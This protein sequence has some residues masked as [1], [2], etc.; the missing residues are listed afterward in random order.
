MAKTRTQ[1]Q[2]EVASYVEKIQ[3]S[4]AMYFVKPKG[5]PAPM[6]SDLKMKLVEDEA[7]LN[8][9]K[10][11]LF[12]KAI[13]SANLNIKDFTDSFSDGERA[14]LFA[15]GDVVKPMKTLKEFIAAN[16]DKVEIIAGYYSGKFISKSS[17]L[18][19]AD[20]PDYSSMMAKTLA[21]LNGV[22]TNFVRVS[23]NNIERLINVLNAVA[24]KK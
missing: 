19:I 21:T 11:T 20:L 6:S 14:V 22:T 7:T 9:V 18:E 12:I 10:N 8:V 23:A 24:E 16:K 17:V 2:G 5:I 4:Q 3:K 13:E 15:N 1:K